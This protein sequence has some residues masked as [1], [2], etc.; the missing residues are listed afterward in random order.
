VHPEHHSTITEARRMVTLHALIYD[1][2]DSDRV[3]KAIKERLH[4]Q[5]GLDHATIEIEH[6]ECA[7]AKNG[8]TKS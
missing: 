1:G 2:Q 5:F 6:R 7:D 4:A 3:V 8:A